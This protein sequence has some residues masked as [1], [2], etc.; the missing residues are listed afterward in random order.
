MTDNTIDNRITLKLLEA[1]R[2]KAA[3]AAESH[4]RE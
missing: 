1:V 2:Q 3:S 4:R